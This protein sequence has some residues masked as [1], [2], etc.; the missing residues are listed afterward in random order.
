MP[1]H[2]ATTAQLRAGE[3]AENDVAPRSDK[4]QLPGFEVIQSLISD[5]LISVPT[6]SSI[7]RHIWQ[8][9]KYVQRTIKHKTHVLLTS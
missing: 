6:V 4:R 8:A 3:L 5:K 7:C 2:L 9:L 1:F